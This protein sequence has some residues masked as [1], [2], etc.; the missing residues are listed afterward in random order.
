MK[1]AKVS[2]RIQRG[3]VK[4]KTPAV[5]T[6]D[7][8]AKAKVPGKSPTGHYSTKKAPS[9]DDALVTNYSLK[10]TANPNAADAKP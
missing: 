6:K 5:R 3:A 9:G 4:A 8:I 10:I 1:K 2:P 7:T